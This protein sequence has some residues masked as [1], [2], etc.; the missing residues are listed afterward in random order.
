M[1]DLL[2]LY[3]VLGLSHINNYLLEVF[4]LFYLDCEQ[5]ARLHVLSDLVVQLREQLYCEV[6]HCTT[7]LYSFGLSV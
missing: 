7:Y 2:L 6:Y 5:F 1:F 3:V 4:F